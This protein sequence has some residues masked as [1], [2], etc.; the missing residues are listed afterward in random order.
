MQFLRLFEIDEQFM[1]DTFL[2]KKTNL[3]MWVKETCF[4]FRLKI[5]ILNSIF[6]KVNCSFFSDLFLSIHY[7]HEPF[8]L[9]FFVK[10]GSQNCPEKLNRVS[11][12]YIVFKTD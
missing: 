10:G 1:I 7:F 12:K 11:K 5:L 6:E 4:V 8:V 3:G 9:L 2:K